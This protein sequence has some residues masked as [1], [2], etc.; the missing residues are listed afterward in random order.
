MAI[1]D[2]RIADLRV[3]WKPGRGMNRAVTGERVVNELLDE[4]VSLQAMVE[5]LSSDY[6]ALVDMHEED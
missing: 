5:K 2:E 3:L 1:T 4:I 6:N